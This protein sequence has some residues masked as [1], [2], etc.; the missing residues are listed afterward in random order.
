MRVCADSAIAY[1]D[2]SK[3]EIE[4]KIRLDLCNDMEYCTASVPGRS[5]LRGGSATQQNT[6]VLGK[7]AARVTRDEVS[8]TALLQ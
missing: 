5:V 8:P 4:Y 6:A 1:L 2:I 3:P 7:Y